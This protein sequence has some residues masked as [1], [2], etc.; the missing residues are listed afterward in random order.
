MVTDSGKTPFAVIL[1]IGPGDAEVAA[2]TDTL[3][4][5]FA[6]EPA[7]T[8]LVLVDDAPQERALE[9]LVAVPEGC[10][11]VRMRSPRQ[12]RVEGPL[13]G[14]AAS[15][16]A[17]LRWLHEHAAVRFTLKLDSDTLVIG[18]FAAQIAAA[19]DRMP[20]V[21]MLGAYDRLCSGERRDFS[22]KAASIRKLARRLSVWFPPLTPG[23]YV[24][25]A[26]S[27]AAA[28]VRRHIQEAFAAG[29]V[30]G[31]HCL[32]AAYA[33]SADA[34]ARFAAR[35]Y[36]DDPLI[37]LRTHGEDVTLSM[38]VRA[39]GLRLH[40]MVGAGEPFGVR[41]RGLANSPEW[42]LAQGHAFIHSVKNDAR[43]PEQEVRAFFRAR[44]SER[45]KTQRRV[46]V[47]S[48]TNVDANRRARP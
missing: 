46:P 5:L 28:T 37:W 6:W 23:Q 2:A 18:P 29:Y 9:S 35:G 39:A 42:L 48:S 16:L 19:F 17:A 11:V 45:E 13:K 36:L 32:G 1:P 44:R 33:L 43:F 20:E 34:V 40:G 26:L 41:W 25:V 27:G 22:P 14:M 21:G 47:P 24:R 8:Y 30:A 31:E 4:S 10:R 12:G 7:V 38:Y 3:Q 15:M